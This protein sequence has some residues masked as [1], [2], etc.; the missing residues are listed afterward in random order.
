MYV[1][2]VRAL[3]SGADMMGDKVDVGLLLEFA[4]D[5]FSLDNFSF[6][7]GLFCLVCVLEEVEV[8]LRFGSLSNVS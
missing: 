8:E 4:L 3:S 1:I 6:C 7:L 2:G 5:I